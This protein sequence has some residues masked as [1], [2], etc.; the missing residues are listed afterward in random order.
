MLVDTNSNKYSI[1]FKHLQN[2][3]S[4]NTSRENIIGKSTQ[5]TFRA[6]EIILYHT[7]G[8]FV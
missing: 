5:L 7:S 8:S 6:I 2:N 3:D 4:G 1:L